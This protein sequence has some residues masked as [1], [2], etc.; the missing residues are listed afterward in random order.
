MT[1]ASATALKQPPSWKHWTR[2]I[3]LS[4]II[5]VATTVILTAISVTS[6]VGLGSMISEKMLGRDGVAD[7]SLLLGRTGTNTELSVLGFAPI[8]ST[9]T[10]TALGE[11][12]GITTAT[13]V[14]RVTNMNGMPSATGYFLWGYNAGALVNTSSTVAVTGTGDYS[15]TITGFD[16]TEY[17]Y[18]QFVTDADGTSY[19]TTLRFLLPSGTGGFLLKTILRVILAGIILVTIVRFGRTPIIMAILTVLGLVG[20][21]FI[22]SLIDTLL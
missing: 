15:V 5:A 6:Q 2:R 8:V 9:Q 19:G 7:S 21:A 3:A 17:V 11:A 18:Y 13:L 10:H 22:S 20:F 16:A 14:G 1:F 4:T 12:G